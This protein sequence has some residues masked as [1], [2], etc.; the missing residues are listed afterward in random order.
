MGL[1]VAELETLFTANVKPFDDATVK[2]ETRR[3]DLAKTPAT[4][5]VEGDVKGALAGMDRV[6]AGAK[7]LTAKDVVARIDANITTAEKK[8]D[9]IRGDLAV[10]DAMDT[11]P[12]VDADIAKARSALDKIEAQVTSLRGTRAKLEVIA[13]T[14]QAE[15]AL[16]DVEADAAASGADAGDAAGKGLSGGIIAAIATIPVAGAIV[17]IG[18]AIGDAL[19]DGLD[20]EVRSDRLMATTG[21]DPITVGRLARAA[22][23]AYAANWGESIAA[24]MDTARVAIQQGLLDPAGMARDSQSIIASLS[25]VADMLGQDIP[26]VS[27]AAATLIRSGLAKDAAGAFDIIVRGMQVGNDKAEDWLDTLI[28]YPSVLEKLGVSG[29]EMTGLI[30]QGDR[31]STRLNSSHH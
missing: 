17:G 27:Q 24:N 1:R 21:L 14:S 16:D 26:R 4:V 2:V 22:G 25:G 8:A 28:E 10:L 12:E 18:A 15:K 30:N 29:A 20:N 23:E 5:T 31:K 19:L 6:E 11:S 13:D 7:A 9:K 3:K